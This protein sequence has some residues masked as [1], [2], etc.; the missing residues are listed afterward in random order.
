[1]AAQ[2]IATASVQYRFAPDAK[3]PA[4]LNDVRSAVQYVVKDQARFKVDS[5]RIIWMG[6]QREGICLCWQVWKSRSSTPH[7]S[8]STWRG[9]QT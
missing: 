1:M 7:D 5:K 6:D 2:G 4:Q 3:F 8:S 9:R